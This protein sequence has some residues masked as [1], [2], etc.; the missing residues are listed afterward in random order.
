MT[1]PPVGS[2]WS[3]LTDAMSV[4]G[5]INW[6]DRNAEISVAITEPASLIS[7]GKSDMRA[8]IKGEMLNLTTS[9]TVDGDG[10]LEGQV[11][12]SGASLRE[13]LR[14]LLFDNHKLTSYTSTYRFMLRFLKTGETPVTEF[15]R[16][17]MIGALGVLNGHL[18]RQRFAVGERPTIA[19]V[20]M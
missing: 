10:R 18:A 5:I 14:W 3:G 1:L 7:G 20:S 12:A 2:G 17:R 9:G 13:T 11:T 16:G 6:R 19:D 8:R 15:L 4:A